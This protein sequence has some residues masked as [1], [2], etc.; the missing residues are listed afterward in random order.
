M[1]PTLNNLVSFF[2]YFAIAALAVYML[3]VGKE[4]LQPLVISIII[5]YLIGSLASSVQ[6]YAPLGSRVPDWL[7]MSV[8]VLLVFVLLWLV[9]N[10]IMANIEQVLA[11]APDYQRSLES[12]LEETA[13][14]LG[15]GQIPTL[16]QMT[17]SL[18]LASLLSAFLSPLQAIAGNVLT[19]TFYVSFLLLEHKSLR[20]KLQKLVQDPEREAKIEAAIDSIEIKIRRYVWIKTIIS[21]L[22]AAFS[23]LVMRV[24]G[25]DFAGFWAVLIFVLNFIPY[26]GSLIAVAF[27]VMLTLVQF[28]SIPM[29][30]IAL[31]LLTTIQIVVGSVLEPRVM[32]SS[33]NLSPLAILLILAIWWSIWG[34]VG[35]II[36]VPMMVI[37]MIVFA[38]FPQTRA[39]AIIMSENGQIDDTRAVPAE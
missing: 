25:I 19:I 21:F 36:C 7:A 15:L 6:Q 12:I 23:Y 33:L 4:I 37:A 3:V 20:L 32:G 28:Q 38:Q 29:F 35:M 2:L 27:P 31:L 34:V 16:D 18:D 14:T 39:V 24:M 26:I 8:A 11:R 22:T 1:Q 9:V 30:L 5:A 10:L 17:E 13:G